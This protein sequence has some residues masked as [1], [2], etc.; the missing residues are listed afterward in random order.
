[1][2][3]VSAESIAEGEEVLVAGIDGLTLSVGR[4]RPEP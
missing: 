3:A 2:K 4:K 1:M